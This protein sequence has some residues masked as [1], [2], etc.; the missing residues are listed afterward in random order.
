[1]SQSEALDQS[2]F[3]EIRVTDQMLGK[4]AFGTVWLALGDTGEQLAV[5][6]VM[7][8]GIDFEVDIDKA[9]HEYELLRKLDHK[10]IVKVHNFRVNTNVANPHADIVMEYVAGGNIANLIQSFGKL[11]E[12]A[13]RNYASET[14]EGLRYLHQFD[15]IHR[16]LKPANIMVTT[17]G[18]VKITDFGLSKRKRAG[19]TTTVAALGTYPYMSPGQMAE[20]LI[21]KQSDI[22]SVGC[23]I[24]EMATSKAPWSNRNLQEQQYV[25]VIGSAYETGDKPD[26]E[27]ELSEG[28]KDLISQCFDAEKNDLVCEDIIRHPFLLTDTTDQDEERL[29][30]ITTVIQSQT[31]VGF[32]T[33]STHSSTTLLPNLGTSTSVVPTTVVSRVEQPC[34]DLFRIDEDLEWATLWHRIAQLNQFKESPFVL[35]YNYLFPLIQYLMCYASGMK[36]VVHF[37]DDYRPF[38]KYFGSAEGMIT[39]VAELNKMKMFELNAST[40]STEN[41][42]K[43]SPRGSMLIRPSKSNRGT[44]ALSVRRDNGSDVL[45]TN[46]FFIMPAGSGY[47]LAGLPGSP[48]GTTLLN[49][50]NNLSKKLPLDFVRGAGRCEIPKIT[51]SVYSSAAG[52]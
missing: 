38:E 29:Q 25:F 1:M 40:A 36:E 37:V 27:P 51:S 32:G 39:E 18:V 49:L 44:L 10:N 34:G 6:R 45:V 8:T 4:G 41:T 5:K 43:N 48:V 31:P 13:V 46:H 11:P 20:N 47:S 14:L 23:T 35:E 7:T 26:I 12:K 50:V 2:R 22:W 21:T 15:I 9:R 42:L 3:N 19:S 52:F 17:D 24:L 28:L 33:S 16:D 30:K